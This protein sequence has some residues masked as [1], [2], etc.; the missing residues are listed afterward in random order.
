M[1]GLADFGQQRD[2]GS[3][4]GVVRDLQEFYFGNLGSNDSSLRPPLDQ[5]QAPASRA[6]GAGSLA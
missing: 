1:T 6:F 4:V 2:I 5:G 3:Y